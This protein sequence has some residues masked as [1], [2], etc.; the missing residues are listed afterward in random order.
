MSDRADGKQPWAA[1]LEKAVQGLKW[2]TSVQSGKAEWSEVQLRK[3]RASADIDAELVEKERQKNKYRL[4][5]AVIM[6]VV[7]IGWLVY[8]GYII[9][10][11]SQGVDYRVQ[12]AMLGTALGAIYTPL[13]V[14]AKY[15]FNGHD[16]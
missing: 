8:T 2:D 4:P 9:V 1:L 13:R 10:N 15:L 11:D 3:E 12:I 5:F 7:A 14:L 16:H 6:L